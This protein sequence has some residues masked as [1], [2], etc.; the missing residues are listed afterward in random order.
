MDG[1]DIEAADCITL[2]KRCHMGIH[3]NGNTMKHFAEEEQEWLNEHCD[4]ATKYVEPKP[5]KVKE[6]KKERTEE[7]KA[8]LRW[9]WMNK[10]RK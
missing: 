6:P 5:K 10:K 2:C 8:W 9:Y 7:E 1:G 4:E 3:K